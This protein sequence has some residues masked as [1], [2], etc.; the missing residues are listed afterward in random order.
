MSKIVDKIQETAVSLLNQMVQQTLDR[1][2]QQV[3]EAIGDFTELSQ[4]AGDVRKVFTANLNANFDELMDRE[5]NKK[6]AVFNFDTLSLVQEEELE[7]IVALEGMVNAARNQHLPVFI[8]CNARL[9][10]LFPQKR[11]DESSNPLDPEQVATAFQEA[12]RPLGLNAEN[13]LS[14]YRVFDSE[15]LQNLDQVMNEANQILI[16]SNVIPDRGMEG[17]GARTWQSASARSAMRG[18]SHTPGTN[19]A[20]EL[21]KGPEELFSIMQNLLHTPH[22]TAGA[23]AAMQPFQP[24]Q[25]QSV[26]MVDQAKLMDI[27]TDIQSK[28][29]AAGPTAVPTSLDEIDRLDISRSLDEVLQTASEDDNTISAVD[30]Q[31]SDIINLVSLLYEAIWDDVSVP[32]PIKE[33]IGRTQITII[34]V[35]LADVEFFNN[36]NYPARTILNEFASA[37]I[38]W[39]EVEEL[40]KDPLYRKIQELVDRIL[41]DYTD[42]IS[43]FEELIREFRSFRAREAAKTRQL[44]QRILRAKERKERLDDIHELVTQKIQERILGQELDPFVGNLLH[45][46]FHKFMVMLVLKEGPGSNAWKQAINTIDVLLWTVQPHEQEEDRDRL[47]TVNP[48]LL[49][50][51]RKAFRITSIGKEEI[52]NLIDKLQQVQDSTFPEALPEEAAPPQAEPVDTA[53]TARDTAPEPAVEE[54]TDESDAI[55]DEHPAMAQVEGLQVGMW[56]E[57]AGEDNNTRCKLA[58][59]INA[60]DKFIFVNRQGVKVVEKTKMRLVREVRDGTVSIISDGLLFSRALESVIGNLRESRHEQ[61]TGSAYNPESA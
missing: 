33:L 15:V 4:Q 53:T 20:N 18:D 40:E 54:A 48:R 14:V 41:V 27:L 5:S 8:S 59:K 51:L 32:I 35:A 26:Q 17:G 61:Q 43:F 37:G 58:A 38:G 24:Q 47:G 34:K 39:T 49:N 25:G 29:N 2:E 36:D 12:L 60:I 45:E 10:S 1:M 28:L 46:H 44:E 52:D 13:S 56:V 11:I 22:S 31:F 21:N 16:E 30:R 9:A 50:N 6:E 57:F 55:T 19:E 42:D 23:P 3:I 7:V